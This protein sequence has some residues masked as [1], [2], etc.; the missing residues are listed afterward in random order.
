MTEV[1]LD[2]LALVRPF[3]GS[4]F[5]SNDTYAAVV[6]WAINSGL[7]CRRRPANCTGLLA[8]PVYPVSQED[9]GVFPR[10]VSENSQEWMRSTV[11]TFVPVVFRTSKISQIS[12]RE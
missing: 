11:E 2:W 10:T 6:I 1:T 3:V 8:K 4:G 7:I 12:G 5:D 9:G